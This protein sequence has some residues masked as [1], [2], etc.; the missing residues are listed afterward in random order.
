MVW[1]TGSQSSVFVSVVLAFTGVPI[2]AL[3]GA[4]VTEDLP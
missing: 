1:G 3:P 4:A 2:V